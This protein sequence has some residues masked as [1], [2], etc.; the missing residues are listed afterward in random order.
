MIFCF[1]TTKIRKKMDMARKMLFFKRYLFG[2]ACNALVARL[3]CDGC[4]V[5]ASET[6]SHSVFMQFLYRSYIRDIRTI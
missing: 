2:G 3:M 4:E 1:E 6:F 5:C